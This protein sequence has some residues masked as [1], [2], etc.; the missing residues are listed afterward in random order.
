MNKSHKNVLSLLLYLQLCA[1]LFD[2]FNLL[3]LREYTSNDFHNTTFSCCYSLFAHRILE[4]VF[5][6]CTQ[7]KREKK[8][9][10]FLKIPKSG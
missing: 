9:L 3:Q 5:Y 4:N 7:P 8:I 2:D 6:R 1:R 10:K